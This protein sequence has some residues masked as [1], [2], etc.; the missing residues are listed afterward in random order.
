MANPAIILEVGFVN[1]LR[2]YAD[3]GV[4]IDLL[5]TSDQLQLLTEL[6]K[7]V[8]NLRGVIDHIG[9]PQIAEESLIS[10]RAT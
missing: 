9:K 5:V 1:A 3:L 8:P 4:P 6:L 2:V 7:Q 10:G